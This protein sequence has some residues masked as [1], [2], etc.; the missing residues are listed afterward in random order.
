M[1]PWI[2]WLARGADNPPVA[3][4]AAPAETT[5]TIV[6]HDDDIIP[7]HASIRETTLIVLPETEKAMGVFCR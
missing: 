4:K 2:V 5:Q 1:I 3:E 7:L 6:A